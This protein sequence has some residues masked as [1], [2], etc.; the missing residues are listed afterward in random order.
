MDLNECMEAHHV[1]TGRP[2]NL[3]AFQASSS[4]LVSSRA[5]P[6]LE[7]ALELLAHQEVA[8]T[9][10]GQLWGAQTY[11]GV[12]W[13]PRQCPVRARRF[14]FKIWMY[15]LRGKGPEITALQGL[16]GLE[17]PV[18]FW[19]QAGR[20]AWVGAL[21]KLETL[22]QMLLACVKGWNKAHWLLGLNS[23]CHVC[24]YLYNRLI[25]AGPS[26]S[27]SSGKRKKMTLFCTCSQPHRERSPCFFYREF[28]GLVQILIDI[29]YHQMN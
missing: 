17:K 29:F 4:L 20:L 8:V 24:A 5:N 26:T 12:L 1:A 13:S 28:C 2:R 14:V 10:P 9:S 18:E 27:G 22:Y 15:S 16:G 11:P 19:E 7:A 25:A 21:R 6:E 3:G 23:H